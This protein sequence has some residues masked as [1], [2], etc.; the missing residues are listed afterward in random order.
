MKFDDGGQR[1]GAG[2][3]HRQLNGWRPHAPSVVHPDF[4][5]AISRAFGTVIVTIH[6]LLDRTT[7]RQLDGVLTDLIEGQGNL[8]VVADLWD[9][10]AIEGGSLAVLE[11]AVACARSQ[12]GHLTLTRPTP[13]VRELLETV[14]LTALE[15]DGRIRRALNHSRRA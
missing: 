3:R 5:L 13:A 7:S 4:R 1:E 9:M 14:G 2:D 6:G 11:A 10:E 15:P 12:G 8:D